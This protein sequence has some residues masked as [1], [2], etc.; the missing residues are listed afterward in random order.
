MEKWT[1]LS[2]QGLTDAA[3]LAKCP[4]L[5]KVDQIAYNRARN[6]LQSLQEE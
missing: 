5:Q 6:I 1:E 4:N 3:I 2:E